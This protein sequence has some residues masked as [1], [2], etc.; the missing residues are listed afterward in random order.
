MKRVSKHINPSPRQIEY[1]RRKLHKELL[2]N[3][4]GYGE[5][6]LP[7]EMRAARVADQTGRDINEVLADFPAATKPLIPVRKVVGPDGREIYIPVR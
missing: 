2:N 5:L 4:E 1:R 7:H 3:Q 6:L